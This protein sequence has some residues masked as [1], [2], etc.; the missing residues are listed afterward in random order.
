MPCER[1]EKHAHEQSAARGAH[2]VQGG[3]ETL[4][5]FALAQEGQPQ[6]AAGQGEERRGGRPE[7]LVELAQ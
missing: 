2:L 7:I 4:A 3:N 6:R 5:R 1:E